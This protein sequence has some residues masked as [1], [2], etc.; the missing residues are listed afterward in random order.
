MN[1]EYVCKYGFGSSDSTEEGLKL[2]IER[3][4]KERTHFDSYRHYEVVEC[5]HVGEVWR[6]VIRY[7]C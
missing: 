7:F 3:I 6:V 2:A 1:T 4:T 5:H